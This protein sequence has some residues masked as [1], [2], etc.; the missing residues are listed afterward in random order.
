MAAIDDVPPPPGIRQNRQFS[1]NQP[2]R[3]QT[4]DILPARARD[5]SP[6]CG[7]ARPGRIRIG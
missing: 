4:P 3:E 2:P 7:V 6:W 1:P 5:E